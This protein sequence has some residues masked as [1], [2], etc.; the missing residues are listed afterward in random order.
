[1][2][3]PCWNLYGSLTSS[4]GVIPLVN[5]SEACFRGLPI[6]DSLGQKSGIV[7]AGCHILLVSR[8]FGPSGVVGSHT[9]LRVPWRK[10]PYFLAL[11]WYHTVGP[12][13]RSVCVVVHTLYIHKLCLR[14]CL[15]VKT[16][17]PPRL[18]TSPGV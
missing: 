12:V 15:S 4:K 9:L 7:T 5:A 6:K 14:S 11:L 17:G 1:M 8:T 2:P 13:S 10:I 3:C 16:K 18:C